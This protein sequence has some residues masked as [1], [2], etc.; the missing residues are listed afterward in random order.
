LVE[1]NQARCLLHDPEH[2]GSPIQYNW[3][4]KWAISDFENKLNPGCKKLL[5]E[6]DQGCW[7]QW[8]VKRGRV[9][10]PKSRTSK[11]L[12]SKKPETRIVASEKFYLK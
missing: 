9:D 2:Y 3:T 7:G 6:E 1:K 5:Q 11:K 12:R 10:K 4:P 8:A